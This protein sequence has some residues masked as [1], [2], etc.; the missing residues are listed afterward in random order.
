MATISYEQKKTYN[1]Q[2]GYSMDVFIITIRSDINPL[3]VLKE[4]KNIAKFV[5]LD[6]RTLT[7]HLRDEYHCMTSKFQYCYGFLDLANCEAAIE[8]LKTILVANEMTRY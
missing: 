2:N 5:E 8:Y 6:T 4:R 3:F 7:K 1:E